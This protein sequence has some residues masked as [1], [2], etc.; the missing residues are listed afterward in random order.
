MGDDRRTQVARMVG[1]TQGKLYDANFDP[2][3]LQAL[4]ECKELCYDYNLVRP[5]RRAELHERLAEIVGSCGRRAHVCPPFWCDYGKNIHLGNG[6]Y[7]NHGLVI[8]DGA[9]VTF[10]EN[11]FVAPNCVFSTAGHPVDTARRNEGLEYA[12]P[13]TVG[14]N[15]WFGM[16]VL[17]CPGVTI[18][19]DVVI[20]A[21]S[22][23]TRDIPSGV[24]AVGNPCR[25]LREIGPRDAERYE[26]CVPSDRVGDEMRDG[27]PE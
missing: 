10:G 17:V 2:L 25:V 8:L 14:D 19:S 21:G 1:E 3:V 7:A 6:F 18:G 24:V 4:D 26:L 12:L 5:T 9:P 15:V 20:G 11:V 13:I 27:F 16:G 23:V 22:V